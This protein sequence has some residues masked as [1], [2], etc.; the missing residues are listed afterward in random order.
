[1]HG[2][3]RTGADP[4]GGVARLG[5]AVHVAPSIPVVTNDFA[6][7]ESTRPWPPIASTLLFG[8]HDALLV[9][10]YIT[11][12]QAAAQADWIATSGRRLRSIYA[13]HGHGDHFFGAGLVRSRF[14]GARLFAHPDALPVMQRQVSPEFLRSFWESR[15]PGQLPERLEVG[16]PLRSDRLELEEESLV[17]VPL[18]FTDVEGTTALFVPSLGLV[19]AG[20]AVYHGVHPRLVDAIHAGRLD[21]W[22]R[23]LDKIDAL[24]PT[25]VVAGHKDPTWDDSP[26]AV[27]ETRE[28]IVTLQALGRKAASTMELYR[29]M[30]ERYPGRL[31]LGALWSSV[32]AV[33]A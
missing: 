21:D 19:A 31:N 5:F 1:M 28:Y 17:V 16:E 11:R 29:T 15:F 30:R 23:A 7:G 12:S 18:G 4:S 33:V 13:T 27:E 8:A 20:D 3:R 2:E 26:V 22:L 9:D 10:S 14:P 6:P 32:T 24:D 25:T